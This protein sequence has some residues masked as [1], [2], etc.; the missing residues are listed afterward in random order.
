MAKEPK[1]AEVAS[2]SE[3]AVD[4]FD[5]VDESTVSLFFKEW[6]LFL[7]LTDERGNRKMSELLLLR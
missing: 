2:V 6:V 3:D 4:D 7:I 1:S 5:E